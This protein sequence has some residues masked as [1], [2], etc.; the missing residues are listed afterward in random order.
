MSLCENSII[1]VSET[2]EREK[3]MEREGNVVVERM[4]FGMASRKSGWSVR[5]RNARYGYQ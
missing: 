2:S 3:K 1:H 4:I 5:M